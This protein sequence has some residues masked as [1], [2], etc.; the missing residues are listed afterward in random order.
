MMRK[1]ALALVMA[2]L[3]VAGMIVG[4]GSTPVA[5]TTESAESSMA[6]GEQE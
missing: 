2:T 3:T 4:C 6:E 5:P 1:K